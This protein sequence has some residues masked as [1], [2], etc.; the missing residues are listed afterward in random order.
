MPVVCGR[1]QVTK[2]K[3]EPH[4]LHCKADAIHPRATINQ[5]NTAAD[6]SLE[7]I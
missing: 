1:Q 3:R 6:T 7:V 4:I 2:R 5:I